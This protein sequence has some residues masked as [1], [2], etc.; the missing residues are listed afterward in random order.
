M[1]LDKIALFGL[2]K[3]RLAWL[4]QRQEV[5]ARNIANSDTPG[6]KPRDLKAFD[7][8]R[9]VSREVGRVTLD[10]SNRAHVGGGP[11]RSADFAEERTRNPYESAP[12]G[13]AV[14][15]EEQMMKVGETTMNYRL[16]A[17]L[18]KKHLNMIRIA[19]GR[20]Q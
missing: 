3:K 20:R 13:N 17:E 19:L 7:F 10:V 1:E 4:A 8:R 9:L 14:I 2:V 6:Y 16:T 15:L 12:A 18:Y 11:R 5:L